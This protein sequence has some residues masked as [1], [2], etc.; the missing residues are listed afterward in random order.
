MK[1]AILA[2]QGA[3]AEHV[4]MM[5]QL[6]HETFEVRQLSDWHQPKD[7]LTGTNLKMV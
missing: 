2:L 6:G 5:Q 1:I 4:K 7:A 3:F